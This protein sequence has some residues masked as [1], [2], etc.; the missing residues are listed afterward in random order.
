MPIRY[1]ML[2]PGPGIALHLF[3]S[4]PT[5]KES[6]PTGMWHTVNR[7]RAASHFV[8]AAVRFYTSQ[9]FPPQN[10]ARIQIVD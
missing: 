9:R 6:E 4:E 2:S 3:E 8:A 1:D 10:V 7:P 5:G